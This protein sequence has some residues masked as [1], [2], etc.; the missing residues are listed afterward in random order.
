[1][2]KFSF[3]LL[4]VAALAL[5]L[6]GCSPGEQVPYTEPFD[7]P[8][9]WRIEEDADVSGQIQNGVYDLLVKTA[10]L[11]IWTTAGETFGDGIYE[12]EA[13]PV[14]GPL[15]NGYGMLFRIDDENDNFYLFQISS[16]GFVWIGRVQDG[17]RAERQAIIGNWWF[18][19][20]AVRQGLNVTNRLKVR[21]EGANMIFYVNDR[22]VGRVTDDTFQRGDIGLMVE[23]FGVGGVRVHF[24]NFSVSPLEN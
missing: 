2:R 13:T 20:D 7:E 8:G 15:D 3:L 18:E 9:T 17:G 19:S 12:V 23:T 22:E 16:D 21:A 1:M 6:A 11:F 10:D 5:T 14:A 24:D 4:L